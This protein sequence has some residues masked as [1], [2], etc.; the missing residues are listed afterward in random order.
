MLAGGALL[1]VLRALDA[2]NLSAKPLPCPWA[3]DI[4]WGLQSGCSG[5]EGSL[6][7]NVLLA[8]SILVG[9]PR[10]ALGTHHSL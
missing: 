5:S 9:K 4:Y 7:T 6:L 2:S 3:T 10:E 1:T 8:S